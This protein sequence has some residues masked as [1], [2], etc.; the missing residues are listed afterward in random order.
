M[1]AI[2]HAK[3][4][5]SGAHRW[6]VCAASVA[7][8]SDIPDSGSTFAAE[9]TAAHDLAEQCLQGKINADTYLNDSVSGFTV[10]HEMVEAVQ[11][12]LDYVRDQPGKLLIEQRVDFRSWV[13]GG[14]GTSDAI[15]L[16]D[17]T[18]TVVDLKYG[19][20]VKVDAEDNPQA[21]L[22]ALGSLHEYDF[23]YDCDNFKLVIVQ[24][25]LDHVS[26]WEI[27]RDELLD[28]AEE[29]LK[30]AAD[31]AL[32]DDAPFQP[33]EKQCRFCKAKATC[34]ALAE[35]NLR[36]ATEGFTVVGD[37]LDL[38]QVAKLTNSEIGALIPQLNTLTDWAKAVEAHALHQME[39]GIDIPG[40]KLVE[41]RSIRKW[42]DDAQ[43][44]AALRKKL[45]VTDIF[46]KKLISPAQAEKK[47]GKGHQVVTQHSIKP[48][49]KPAL[50]PLSDKRPALEIDPTEG[51]KQVA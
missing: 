31:L 24:P 46:T 19:R 15:I 8:E 16:N 42:E 47:L 10:D 51:F 41:G 40:Y 9:G 45:K 6:M 21:M 44:E 43:A 26:E 35:H 2:Q 30:P 20:G 49:G 25:R 29:T 37:P 1:A 50:A 13:P 18:A 22:Y 38:K 48:E 17:G 14:F 12:Y 27:S 7:M 32:S 5:A 34:R 39:I 33:G 4:S 28:W 11:L 3:L 36:V 23:L